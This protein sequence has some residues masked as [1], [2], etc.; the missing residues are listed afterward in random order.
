MFSNINEISTNHSNNHSYSNPESSHKLENK[1][2][3]MYK[4]I[5]EKFSNFS[6]NYLYSLGEKEIVK[7]VRF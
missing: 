1:T 7:L 5:F 2:L 6:Y 3:K 4:I